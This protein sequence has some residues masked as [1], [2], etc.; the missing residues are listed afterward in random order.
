MRKLGSGQEKHAFYNTFGA[1]ACQSWAEGVGSM[2]FIIL[3]EPLHDDAGLGVRQAC[4][5]PYFR[6][7]CR[8]EAGP[9]ASKN[10][11]VAI[12]SEPLLNH[13]PR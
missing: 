7:P 9:K 13:N 11:Y 3:S 6:N 12:F 5:L 4:I 1:F 8:P 10:K 2:Y